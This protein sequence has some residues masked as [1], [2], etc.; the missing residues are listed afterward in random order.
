MGEERI[1]VGQQLKYLGVV[2]D[3]RLK[4]EA[5][6]SQLMPRV[7][8]VTQNLGRLMPNVRGPKEKTRHLYAAVAN[9][10]TL[11]GA[12]VWAMSGNL[13]C[14]N[15]K[16]LRG[17]QRRLA[18][19]VIRGYRTVSEEAAITLAGMTPWDHLAKA[20]AR[21]YREIRE[22]GDLEKLEEERIKQRAL[23]QARNEWRS[24]LE[25]EEAT[26]SRAVLAILPSWELWANKGPAKLTFRVTQV[27]TGHGCFG[28][29]LRRIGAEETASC[30]H[31]PESVDSAQHT[32]EV[33]EA[34]SEQRRK[35]VEAI[36]PD[37]SPVSLV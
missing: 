24:E 3:S 32:V 37:L 8:R 22:K 19:R 1:P 13:T 12:P 23:L 2:L 4:Y 31:C 25:S 7:E 35:L 17:L 33:C 14:K 27:L 16:M 34:F 5:H 11:Y 29:Y 6:F 10:M 9:S 18:I 15:I 30:R 21:A 26:R 36:G 28:E 20:Y